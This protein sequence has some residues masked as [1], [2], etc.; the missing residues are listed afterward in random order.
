MY[1]SKCGSSISTGAG[2]CPQCGQSTY[3]V[4]VLAASVPPGVP[5]FPYAGFWHRFAAYLIDAIILG[6]C[7]GGIIVLVA[8]ITGL[9]SVVEGLTRRRGSI[10]EAVPAL[11]AV[12]FFS[13]CAIVGLIGGWLYH[14][15]AESSEWQATPG[16][17]VLGLEV[18]DLAGRKIS[19]GRA[20]GRYFGK[21][22][23]SLIPLGIG[24]ILA[25]FTERRQAIHDMLASC[26]VLRRS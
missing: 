9:G 26:L 13:I 11:L 16:K 21:F 24:Y 22:I 12:G 2:F 15:L 19:F 17:R 3:A 7:C 1:C 10:D 20:S 18:T 23:T 25:A 4:P 6:V 8:V 14:A 5:R